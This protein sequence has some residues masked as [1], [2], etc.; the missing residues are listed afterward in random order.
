MSASRLEY[1]ASED[2]L[3]LACRVSDDEQGGTP[4]IC[5]PGITRNSRD[6]EELAPRLAEHGPVYCPDFRGRGFSARDPDWRNYHPRT[7]VGDV[8]RLLDAFDIERAAFVGTSLGGL[9]SMLL[10]LEA[11]ARVACIVLNDIGPVI[12]P[13]GLDRIKSYIGRMPPVANWPQAA[14]QARELYGPSLPDL[15]DDDWLRLARRGYRE[16][17]AG[18]PVLDFDPM[19]GEAA[20]K[21]GAGLDE[22]WTLFEDITGIPM[23]V[24]QGELSDILTDDIVAGMRQRKPDLEHVV[25]ANRGHVPLLDE[26]DVLPAIE[27]FLETP[28]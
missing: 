22:P 13:A 27:R 8:R 15:D 10:A 5:L 9:V 24:V 18:Q 20:R 26:R 25:A 11:P 1:Y 4:V 6:F 14:A 23:L 12:N 28:R 2:G 7:Y 3:E 19:I 21:V 16:D 17:A